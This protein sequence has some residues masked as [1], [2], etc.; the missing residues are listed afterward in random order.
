MGILPT[1]SR[2]KGPEPRV[3]RNLFV[4][5]EILLAMADWII[6]GILAGLVLFVFFIYLMA[7]R[8]VLGF[9]EGMDGGR[10]RRS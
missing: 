7:R 4:R 2:P 6:Y 10:D 5:T 8:T 3:W 9:Q 1:Y